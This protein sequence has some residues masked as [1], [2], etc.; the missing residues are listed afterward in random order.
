DPRAGPGDNSGACTHGPDPNY[1]T[2][3]QDLSGPP[4][5]FGARLVLERR[6]GGAKRRSGGV[7]NET[8]GAPNP[9][10]PEA[11]QNITVIKEARSID[12]TGIVYRIDGPAD[13]P[14]LVLVHGWSADLR[15]WG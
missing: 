11:A 15:C 6:S 2:P 7:K 9:A 10:T 13:A 4:S 5:R 14:P 8:K 3:P 12:G 1:R